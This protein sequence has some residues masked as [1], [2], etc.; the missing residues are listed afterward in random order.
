[1][2]RNLT[3]P[4]GGEIIGISLSETEN[5]VLEAALRY[6]ERGLYAPIDSNVE[7]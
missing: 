1:M 4:G 2:T 5:V 3:L 7:F 6:K